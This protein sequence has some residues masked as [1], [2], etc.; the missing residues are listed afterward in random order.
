[1]RMSVIDAVTNVSG[2]LIAI[3]TISLFLTLLVL[4]VIAVRLWIVAFS[5]LNA[6]R[7]V[8]EERWRFLSTA[9]PLGPGFLNFQKL[10]AFLDSE[11]LEVNTEIAREKDKC[12]RLISLRK[13]V[14]MAVLRGFG[15]LVLALLLQVL[16]VR[17]CARI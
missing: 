9:G 12:R 2:Y 13:K 5:L 11:E 7:G 17:G 10:T 14:N 8:D 3:I 4:V 1:M 15:V 16:L 6:I